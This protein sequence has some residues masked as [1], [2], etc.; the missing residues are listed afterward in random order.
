MFISRLEGW[1]TSILSLLPQEAGIRPANADWFVCV[2]YPDKKASIYIDI[3]P[4]A[5][6][7]AK[8]SL[9]KGEGVYHDDIAEISRLHFEGIEIPADAGVAILMS[10]GWR[11]GFYFDFEPIQPSGCSR[12]YDLGAFLGQMFAYLSAQ[13]LFAITDDDWQELIAQQWYPFITL[14]GETIK[15]MV[16]HVRAG[17]PVDE[18]LPRVAAEVS[19]CIPRL[20]ERWGSSLF[21]QPHHQVIE[22]ALNRHLESDYVSSTSILYPRIEGVIRSCHQQIRHGERATQGALVKTVTGADH[23]GVEDFSLLMPQ[24]FRAYLK[25]VYFANFTAGEPAPVSR[26][27]I[28]HGVASPADLSLKAS[29]LGILVLDQVFFHLKGER[30]KSDG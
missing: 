7:R 25:R 26:H 16:N 21:F 8:R 30:P 6:I 13:H 17:W 11:K 23:A 18:L 15:K 5:E 2:I 14:K 10:V 24:R 1:P 20:L 3:R 19:E 9:K 12:S 27:S 29:L 4:I 28:A 22:H